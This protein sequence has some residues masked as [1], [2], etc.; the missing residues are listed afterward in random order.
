[1]KLINQP[2]NITISFLYYHHY[3]LEFIK[4]NSI[5]LPNTLDNVLLKNL[6]Q[7]INIYQPVNNMMITDRLDTQR[8]TYNESEKIICTVLEWNRF[9]KRN[10]LI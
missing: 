10:G 4:K 2:I 7:N 8:L 1:M 3:S 5:H 9:L 6:K